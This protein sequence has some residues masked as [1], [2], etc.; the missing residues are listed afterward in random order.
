MRKLATI[1][2]IGAVNPIP[3]ADAIEVASVGGWA[4][5]VK[6]DEYR[7]GDL[8]IY[9]EIASWIPHD[10][11]PFLSKGQEPREYNEVKG[12]RLRTVKLRGQVSQGL[13]LPLDTLPADDPFNGSWTEGEDVSELLNIQKWEAPIP[14]Q[15]AG[16]VEGPFPS[17]VPKTDQ[18]RIQNLTEEFQIWVDSA[19]N[20][21]VTEKL[22]GSS[23]TVYFKD[24]KFGVCSRNWA[25]R[26]NDTNSLWKQARRYKLEAILAQEG[27][28][29][30]QGEL[31]GEGI[32]GNPYKIQGQDFFV[33]DIF[34]INEQRYLSPAERRAFVERNSLKHVPVVAY[35]AEL[36]DTLGIGSVEQILQFAE[37]KSVLHVTAEREGLVFKH[38]GKTSFK[39]I[40]NRFLLKTGN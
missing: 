5:V 2:R 32:Q 33:Y 25:L 22:D 16:D 11:A 39:A 8:A 34:N 38:N 31:V 1:R 35:N 26:E 3:G 4:V 21:E 27:N 28:F 37:G 10:L 24:G 30:V 29:A 15:L 23:M 18:E 12:E 9:C 6:K 14:A 40:S 36:L 17:Y 20:W 19:V 13:L 7:T